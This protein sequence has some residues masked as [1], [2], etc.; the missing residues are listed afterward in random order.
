[1]SPLLFVAALAV[2]S[3]AM[4]AAMV[5]F[6]RA[7]LRREE[8]AVQWGLFYAALWVL[9]F[10]LAATFLGDDLE[11]NRNLLILIPGA[12]IVL[13]ALFLRIGIALRD[14]PPPPPPRRRVF[15]EDEEEEEEEEEPPPPPPPTWLDRG[16]RV[17]Q[18]VG[19]LALT[20]ALIVIGQSIG[21]LHDLD[22]AL[23]PY[24]ADAALLLG[25]LAAAGF[26]AFMIGVFRGT[27][28]AV[29]GVVTAIL[30]GS[31]LA[32]VF[33][34]PGIKLL[35]IATVAYAALRTVMGWRRLHLPPR[36]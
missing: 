27:K 16:K 17:L 4:L 14:A 35:V 34:P 15:P 12:M 33:A 21:A 18:W 13:H 6:S 2:L 19:M 22:A 7:V 23:A 26:A 5:R 28:M 36:R 31:A 1:M 30:S 20:L 24:R 3:L 10:G 32:V 29:A 25:V 8:S 11:R 9:I